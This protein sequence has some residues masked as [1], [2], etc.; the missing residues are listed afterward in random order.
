MVSRLE[1]GFVLWVELTET[2]NACQLYQEAVK[3]HI[4]IAPRQ[5]FPSHGAFANCIRMGYG[6]IWDSNIDYGL[7]VLGSLIKKHMRR[8]P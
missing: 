7:K 4:S 2:V 1:G 8:R 3:H 6:K 5:I